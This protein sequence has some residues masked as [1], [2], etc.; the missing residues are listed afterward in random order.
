[1]CA[2]GPRAQRSASADSRTENAASRRAKSESAPPGSRA[3]NLT[4]AVDRVGKDVIARRPL[5]RFIQIDRLVTVLVGM[6]SVTSSPL[7]LPRA[8]YT[9]FMAYDPP[10]AVQSVSLV[11]SLGRGLPDW[12][13]VPVPAGDVI[14]L[15]VQHELGEGNYRMAIEASADC[16]WEAQVVLNS[17][18]SWETPSRAFQRT[19]PVPDEI[20]LGSG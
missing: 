8:R 6:G 14:A 13:S 15:L 11:D 2:D 3:V 7:Y 16:A 12:A 18:L 9:I 5:S 10:A 1:M 20:R 4:T 19:S 17:T